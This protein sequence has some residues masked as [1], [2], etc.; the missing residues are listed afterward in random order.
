MTNVLTTHIG[1]LPYVDVEPALD[2]TF[3]FD[4]PVLFTLPKLDSNQYMQNELLT[5]LNL[6]HVQNKQIILAD[7]Y[8]EVNKDIRPFYADEFF[9]K[10]KREKQDQFKYQLIGPLSFYKLIKQE[11]PIQEVFDFLLVKYQTLVRDLNVYGKL[12]FSIDEP[13]LSMATDGE[14][15]LLV[16]FFNKLKSANSGKTFIHL[17][18]KLEQQQLSFFDSSW[19]N[20]DL[21]LYASDYFNSTCFWGLKS[22]LLPPD[23]T[24][25][26]LS[27]ELLL[28][29]SCG[30]ANLSE[31]D[32]ISVQKNLSQAKLLVSNQHIN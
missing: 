19:L 30:L 14:L 32:I 28:G 15:K 31:M 4:L 22:G 26:D 6:G 29:P 11:I 20:L 1:S 9:S 7:N 13:L 17:C 16:D 18:C 24:L 21:S 8:L 27:Q 5:L 2:F 12:Y 10:L 23:V 25:H 3:D